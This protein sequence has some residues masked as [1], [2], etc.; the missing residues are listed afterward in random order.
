MGAALQSKGLQTTHPKAQ[1]FLRQFH[2]VVEQGVNFIRFVEHGIH[3]QLLAAAAYVQGSV[4]AQNNHPLVRFAVFASC[5]DTQTTTLAKKQVNNRQI[6]IMGRLR[7][8][9][10]T[11]S[12]SF[13][14]ANGHHVRKFL[15]CLNQVLTNRRVVFDKKS[16]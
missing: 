8:P 12:F 14:I 7:E 6:P 11:C 9:L 2:A 4:I 15:Q 3:P 13:C 5:H 16:T 1:W 10:D